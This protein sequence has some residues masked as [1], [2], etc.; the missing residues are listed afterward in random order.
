MEIDCVHCF[1]DSQIN[2]I[3]SLTFCQTTHFV[4]SCYEDFS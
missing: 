1:D 3:I 4:A 2:V